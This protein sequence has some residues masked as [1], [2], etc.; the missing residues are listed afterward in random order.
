MKILIINLKK[1]TDRKHNIEQQLKQL[2]ISNYEFIEAIDGKELNRHLY[3]TTKAEKM[4]FKR[5]NRSRPLLNTEIACT[6]SHIKAYERCL[7]LQERCII[8]EDDVILTNQ[9]YPINIDNE[10]DLVYFGYW[11]FKENNFKCKTVLEKYT[12]ELDTFYRP[13]IETIIIDNKEYYKMP[14]GHIVYGAYAYSPSLEL[15]HKLLSN[16]TTLLPADL[17]VNLINIDKYCPIQITAYPNRIIE[18]TIGDRS[19]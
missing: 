7:E 4:L 11:L 8:L 9:F 5:I 17:I 14:V 15:C 19:E 1:S 10:Y 18:S 2:N 13:N 6:L 12:N 3:D 16:T